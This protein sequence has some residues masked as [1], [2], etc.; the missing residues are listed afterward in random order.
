MQVM[1]ARRSTPPPGSGTPPRS[2]PSRPDGLPRARGECGHRPRHGHSRTRPPR[3]RTCSLRP[4]ARQPPPSGIRPSFFTSTWI[5]SPG[6]SCS[7]RFAVDREARI[8]APVTGANQANGGTPCRARIREIVRAGTCVTGANRAGPARN[9]A[10]ASTST[11]SRSRLVRLGTDRGW[12]DRSANP[13]RPSAR[14]RATQRG[15]HCLEAPSSRATCATG[16]PGDRA[17]GRPGDDPPP[18][19][20]RGE[21][22]REPSDEHCRGTSRPPGDG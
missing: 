3:P 2:R 21:P 8:T 18:P 22:S 15:A 7:Y 14:N 19:A 12:D 20:A 11:R 17:T 10:R 9:R 1:P 4:C 6:C 16:R 5:R 13:R